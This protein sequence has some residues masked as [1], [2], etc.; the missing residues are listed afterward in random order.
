MIGVYMNKLAY[1]NKFYMQKY[2]LFILQ[3]KEIFIVIFFTKKLT[4]KL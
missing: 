4:K 3:L 1:N 2:Y